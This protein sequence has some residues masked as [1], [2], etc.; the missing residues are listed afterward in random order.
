MV[1]EVA[2]F[3]NS[4]HAFLDLVFAEK[5]VPIHVLEKTPEEGLQ[6][7]LKSLRVPLNAK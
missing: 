3:P 2:K 1:M 5:F 7:E 6:F 4:I